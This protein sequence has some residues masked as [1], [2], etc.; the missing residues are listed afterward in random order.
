MPDREGKPGQGGQDEM[1]G[2]AFV[3]V[4]VMKGSG[5]K[6]QEEQTKQKNRRNAK[7]SMPQVSTKEGGG[8]NEQGHGQND[9]LGRLAREK[10]TG[11]Q[12]Q[13]RDQHGHRQAMYGAS[14]RQGHAHTIK[15]SPSN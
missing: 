9:G 7:L 1:H 2:F 6:G 5:P 15:C 4:I 14:H 12:G 13:Q 3:N 10:G 8:G 11:K